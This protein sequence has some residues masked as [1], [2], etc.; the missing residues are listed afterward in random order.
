MSAILLDTCILADLTNANSDWFEWSTGQL[1]QLDRDH[2]FVIN[3]VIY[4]EFSVVFETIEAVEKVIDVLGFDVLPLSRDAL[5]L[6]GKAFANYRQRKR[7]KTNVLPDFFIGA[8]AAVE[9]LTLMTRDKGRF[10]SYFPGVE[11]ILPVS[12]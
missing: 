3:P 8:H 7:S 12:N 11:L 4:A 9:N 1:E 5:F 2:R 10:S 6:A